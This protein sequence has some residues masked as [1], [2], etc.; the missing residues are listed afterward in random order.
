MF[1]IWLSLHVLLEGKVA[2]KGGETRESSVSLPTK[3]QE[4]CRGTACEWGQDYSQFI[5]LLWKL[6]VYTQVPFR[7]PCAFFYCIY[8]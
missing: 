7:W 1:S 3:F 2:G 8:S 5:P 6:H 4:P